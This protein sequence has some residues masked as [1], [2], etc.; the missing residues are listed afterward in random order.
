MRKKRS[1]KAQATT[2]I[3][4]GILALIGVV[5]VMYVTKLMTSEATLAEKP[6]DPVV[7]F[8]QECVQKISEQGVITLGQ[9][10][11]YIY[12]DKFPLDF[13]EKAPFNS[14]VLKISNYQTAPYW[15]YQKEGGYDR[16][17]IPMLEKTNK[18]DYSVQDQLERYVEENL[19]FCLNGFEI[20]KEQGLVVEPEGEITANVIFTDEDIVVTVN[21]PITL[22]KEG[23]TTKLDT[24][25]T[26]LRVRLKK[27]YEFA[28]DIATYEQTTTFLEQNTMNLITIYGRA[29]KDYLPPLFGGMDIKDCGDMVYWMEDDVSSMFKNMLSMN[30]PY[31]KIRNSDFEGIVV[32]EEKQPDQEKRENSQGIFDMMS[33]KISDTEYPGINVLFEYR[34]K[35]PLFVDLGQKGMI[36]PPTQVDF[37]YLFGRKCVFVYKFAYSFKYPVLTTLIDKDS[38]INEQPYIFQFP[39]L[40]VTKANF[41][42]MGLGD[43]LGV[44]EKEKTDY[45]CSADQRTSGDSIVTVIDKET[46]KPLADAM[47][48]FQCGP[49]FVEEYNESGTLVNM[50]PFSK[51]CFVGKS[52]EDGQFFSKFPP[53][54]GGAILSVEKPGYAQEAIMLGDVVPAEKFTTLLEMTPMKKL[55]LEL[56]RYSVI[57]P[58]KKEILDAAKKAGTPVKQGIVLDDDA[59]VTECNLYT[60]PIDLEKNYEAMVTFKKVDPT[61]TTT[62]PYTF[63]LYKDELKPEIELAPGTYQVEVLLVRHQKWKGELD[64]KKDSESFEVEGTLFSSGKEMTYPDKDIEVESVMSGGVFYITSLDEED[65]KGADTITLTVFDEG[66]PKSIENYASAIAHREACSSLNY[67][68]VQPI[69]S[70]EG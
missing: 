17:E 42:R 37:N 48:Y 51:R 15:Y 52:D 43:Y 62:N 21:Y 14:P 60:P 3:I 24:F 5:G 18:G 22:K 61:V 16:T 58:E 34:P 40:A 50:T 31:L 1:S 25:S 65:M 44:E 46:T 67:N 9:Q 39:M 29:D 49:A 32:S 63:A 35:F 66:K 70:M 10:G 33:K 54:W 47:V 69:F 57:P 64:I 28:R 13:I 41:P 12:L 8:T 53:C 36:K 45:M 7:A 2:F 23:S 55:K 30:L 38:N 27:I 4:I 6:I 56:K 20:F 68:K 19:L 11:G 59:Q 26:K